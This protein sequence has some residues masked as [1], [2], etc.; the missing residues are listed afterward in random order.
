MPYN[1]DK[2]IKKCTELININSDQKVK[3]IMIEEMQKMGIQIKIV[4]VTI[5]VPAPVQIT[6]PAPVQIANNCSSTESITIARSIS[7]SNNT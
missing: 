5:T 1:N 7:T 6:V 3:N 4:P 2:L